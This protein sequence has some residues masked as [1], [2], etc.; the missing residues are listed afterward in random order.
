MKKNQTQP[1]FRQLSPPGQK[2]IA[3]FISLMFFFYFVTSI[4]GYLW[5]VLIFLWKD[6]TFRNRGF[7]YGPWLP[8]YG[9]GAVVFYLFFVKIKDHPVRVFFL[10]VLVGSGLE[11]LIGWLLDTF[12]NLRYWDYSDYPLNLFGYISLYSALGFGIAGV[13]WVCLFSRL[14]EKLRFHLPLN[15]RYTFHTLL[16][17]LLLLDV[18]A[19]LIFPNTGTGITFSK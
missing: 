11:F 8:V 14:L 2:Q 7:L 12:W 1:D 18:S 17:L 16:V 9:V 15:F 6:G 4:G 5:E 3:D 10:S 13:L 19:A